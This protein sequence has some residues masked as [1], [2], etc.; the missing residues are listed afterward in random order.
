MLPLD[1]TVIQCLE[2]AVRALRKPPFEKDSSH[3][4]SLPQARSTDVE[5]EQL[6]ALL[7]KFMFKDEKVKDKLSTLSGGEKVASTPSLQ[8]PA[9]LTSRNPNKF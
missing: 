4:S 2:D 3:Q 7:G 6:R 8:L 9:L 5:Y 1:K